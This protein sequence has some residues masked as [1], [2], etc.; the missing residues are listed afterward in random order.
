MLS[1]ELFDGILGI[2]PHTDAQISAL[3]WSLRVVL[4]EAVMR[5]EVPLN[6]LRGIFELG[7][8]IELFPQL[9]PLFCSSHH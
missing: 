4:R 6:G 5:T 9:S 3:I 7:V 2:L 8:A 1:L